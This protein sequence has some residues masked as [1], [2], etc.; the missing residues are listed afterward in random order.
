[1]LLALP[2]ELI[3]AVV[4]L[5]LPRYTGRTTCP[6]LQ[7]LLHRLCLISKRLYRI[8]LPMLEEA[9][10]ATGGPAIGKVVMKLQEHRYSRFKYI[11]F[12]GDKG[13]SLSYLTLTMLTAAWFL[14]DIRL[15]ELRKVDLVAARLPNTTPPRTP[16]RYGRIQAF[17]LPSIVELGLDRVT[18][19]SLAARPFLLPSTFPALRSL[20]LRNIRL[21]RANPFRLTHEISLQ[22]ASLSI[23]CLLTDY[24]FEWSSCQVVRDASWRTI[25]LRSHEPYLRCSESYAGPAD[26]MA[27]AA[28][29]RII[30]SRAVNEIRTKVL[31]I[32]HS[33]A[34]PVWHADKVEEF[35]NTWR[36]RGV[37]VACWRRRE[38][39]LC[40]KFLDKVEKVRRREAE[41]GGGGQAG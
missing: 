15:S 41:E 35:L 40:D 17:L 36:A 20:A 24:G 5:A 4:C 9:A 14:R 33:F 31:N 32:P 2:D 27:I 39:L 34:T 8:S 12:R 22:L 26:S 19:T 1:M 18:C 28:A 11:S 3:E 38:Q 29:L 7:C 21:P 6:R 37:K 13:I 10:S 16:G 30:S 25:S 23:D